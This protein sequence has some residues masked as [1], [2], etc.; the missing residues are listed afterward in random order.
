MASIFS[1]NSE[2]EGEDIFPKYQTTW[3]SEITEILQIENGLSVKI[4]F[5][6]QFVSK[7]ICHSGDEDVDIGRINNEIATVEKRNGSCD[8]WNP[9][10]SCVR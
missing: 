5:F 3:F 4:H 9:L 10:T 6:F 8:Q 1:S 2:Q 7:T